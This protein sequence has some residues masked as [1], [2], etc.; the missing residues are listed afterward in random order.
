MRYLAVIDRNDLADKGV[1]SYIQQDGKTF[2]ERTSSEWKWETK[3]MSD[4][5]SAE[6]FEFSVDFVEYYGHPVCISQILP[7]EIYN[8]TAYSIVTETHTGN[9]L[10][11]FTEKTVKP[12]LAQRLFIL[13]SNRYAL[14]ALR[15]L[16]FKT[17]DG[18]IDESYDEIA[19]GIDRHTAALNQLKWLCEQD[20]EE[21]LL[22]CRDIVKHNFDVMYSTNWYHQF[23][24]PF[25]KQFLELNQV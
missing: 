20:Q 2:A 1:V 25:L 22:K 5:K 7:I 15:Q 12:I 19:L 24:K 17:F 9:E 4:I 16:G 21:I 10:V 6:K 18:I 8:Q 11:F 14:K 13:I 3:G 23:K